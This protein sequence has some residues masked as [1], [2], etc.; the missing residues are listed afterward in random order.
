VPDSAITVPLFGFGLGTKSP[1]VSAQ[2]RENL[3]V[4]KLDDPDKTGLALFARPGLS[5]FTQMQG[6]TVGIVGDFILDNNNGGEWALFVT[7][8][9]PGAGSNYFRVNGAGQAGSMG[10]IASWNGTTLVPIG[11]VVRS[12]SGYNEAV[13]VDG[14]GGFHVDTSSNFFT[15][16]QFRFGVFPND[17][18]FPLGAKSV[19]FIAS[20]FVCDDPSAPGQFRWSAAG[21]GTSW[22]ALD[23]ANAES[24]GD[25]LTMVF[26]VAGQLLLIGTS[27]IEFWAP[28]ATGASGQQPFQRVGGAN[29][30]WGTTAI[31][32]VRKVNN[33]VMFMGRN[34]GGNR[35][36]VLLQGYQAQVVSTPDVEL[37]IQNDPIADNATAFF[38]TINGHSF[39]VL[40]LS[41][42]SWAYDLRSQSWSKWTTA[43]G[44]FAGQ[45]EIPGFGKVLVTDYRNGNLYALDAD[46]LD[47]NGAPIVR[48]VVSKHAWANLSRFRCAEI[49]I[50]CQTGVGSTDGTAADHDQNPQVMLQWSKDGGH[51]WG[52]EVWS[53]LGATGNYLTRA[54]WR[55]LGRS[56]DWLFKLR[57]T[58][59]VKTVFIGAAAIFRP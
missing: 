14:N 55:N 5:L 38:G 23:F 52:N 50:D 45:Y 20:R 3:Y 7:D 27:T 40:N 9:Q 59:K 49:A 39:Y 16:F 25:P 46:T 30:Q 35:Q 29:I 17:G 8:T 53:S 37:A 44:R 24:N 41:T 11:R 21:D 54:V 1:N 15:T 36:I 56:R 28:T 19:A 32:T 42:A 33:A 12:A 2:M 6:T 4:E 51:V 13:F 34:L 48:E 22:S 43:G 58:D 57:V 47:D 10:L 18:S 26:E 31:D